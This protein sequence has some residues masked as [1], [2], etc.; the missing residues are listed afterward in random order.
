M[1]DFHLLGLPR[2]H[3]FLLQDDL[4]AHEP[5]GYFDFPAHHVAPLAERM[6]SSEHQTE[7]LQR[8]H[9]MRGTQEPTAQGTRFT[10]RNPLGLTR[11]PWAMLRDA[12]WMRRYAPG[13][14]LQFEISARRRGVVE[15]LT[16]HLGYL[17]EAPAELRPS[18]GD[19]LVHVTD[20][21]FARI[22]KDWD[23]AAPGGDL[24]IGPAA[25]EPLSEAAGLP[26]EPDF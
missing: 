9:E 1:D 17:S 22:S 20:D 11:D 21:N 13:E 25:Q 6:I 7:A 3:R 2:S 26:S 10:K 14:Y 18:N 5:N 19:F 4:W 8:R 15:L 12:L 24:D 16:Y 23:A